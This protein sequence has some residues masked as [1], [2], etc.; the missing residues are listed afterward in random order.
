MGIAAT[1]LAG[2]AL[3]ADLPR[4]APAGAFVS[5]GYNW[6]GF[7][8]GGHVGYGWANSSWT[9]VTDAASV[10]MTNNGFL[11]GGQIG[12]NYQVGAV[13]FGLEADYSRTAIKGDSPT[14][15]DPD[16][17][18]TAVFNPRLRWTSLVTGRVGYAFDR[19]L[20]YVK[21]G[22]AFGN[23]NLEARDPASGERASTSFN[24]TGW[25]LGAGL[26]VALDQNWSARLEYAYIDF[27]SKNQTLLDDDASADPTS[28][29]Y[30]SQQVKLGVNYRFGGL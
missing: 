8:V 6:T 23:I 20:A 21:G 17:G 11:G 27:G 29:R 14:F 25:T 22:A 26:E 2:T 1:L 4:K 9:A 5:P 28:V 30:R 18:D 13:V 16:D 15:V 24:R 10:S 19:Y 7:Y 3:A 12:F